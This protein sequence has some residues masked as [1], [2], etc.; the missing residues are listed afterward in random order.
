MSGAAET[1]PKYVSASQLEILPRA[2]C[3]AATVFV[4][5]VTKDNLP[6]PW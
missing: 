5:A 4:I 3:N 1:Y 6:S 2:T